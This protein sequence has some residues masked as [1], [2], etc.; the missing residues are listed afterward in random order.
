[1]SKDDD[2]RFWNFL[3][4]EIWAT[5]KKMEE[6]KEMAPTLLVVFG[7]AVIIGCAIWYFFF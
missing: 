3:V 1:M 2:E 7:L 6:M 4:Y 5:D